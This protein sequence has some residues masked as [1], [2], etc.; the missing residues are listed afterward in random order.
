MPIFLSIEDNAHRTSN[1]RYFL[2]TVEI[3]DHNIM[4]DGKN[5]LDQPVKNNSRTYERIRKIATVPGDDYTASYL[6]DYPYF[7]KYYK[8]VAIDLS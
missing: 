4:I 1:N 8:L 7:K 2:P 6:L 3:K 5:F